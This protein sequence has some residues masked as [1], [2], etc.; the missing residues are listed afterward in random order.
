VYP[1][2]V[3][4]GISSVIFAAAIG[5]AFAL[6]VREE[7]VVERMPVRYV[8][9]GLLIASGIGFVA[10]SIWIST[11]GIPGTYV[12]VGGAFQVLFGLLLATNRYGTDAEV[13]NPNPE[14]DA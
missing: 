4:W 14:P 2:Y 10:A 1:G 9:G 12:P 7:A 6:F 8:A 5:L 11:R 13:V 3:L